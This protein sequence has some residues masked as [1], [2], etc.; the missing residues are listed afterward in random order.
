MSD[1]RPRIA[2]ALRAGRVRHVTG[3]TPFERALGDRFH[4]LAP[5]V[6]QLHGGIK[7]SWRGQ[8]TVS[9]GAGWRAA[10][11]RRLGGFPPAMDR[12]PFALRIARTGEGRD[13]W[14]RDF[15]GFETRS[16]LW[17]DAATGR[18]MERFGAVT[19]TLS[20]REDRDALHVA[21]EAA[22]L[23]PGPVLPAALVPKS[24]TVIWQDEAGRYRFDVSARFGARAAVIRYQGWLRADS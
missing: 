20:A 4:R 17:F 1:P 14:H 10:A 5:Q 21:V 8:V 3:P 18:M 19:C 7:P 6:R 12:A 2:G 13:T 24:D 15:D 11:A 23:H 16:D 9:H 22:R